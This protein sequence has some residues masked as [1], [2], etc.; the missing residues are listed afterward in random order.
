MLGNIIILQAVLNCVDPTLPNLKSFTID[1]HT[2]EDVRSDRQIQNLVESSMKI[3]KLNAKTLKSLK[4]YSFREGELLEM[5][6]Y[7]NF[8][9]HEFHLYNYSKQYVPLQVFLTQQT[10]LQQLG[11]YNFEDIGILA[12]FPEMPNLRKLILNLKNTQGDIIL[13]MEILNN[14]PR[15]EHLEMIANGYVLFTANLRSNVHL[16][17]FKLHHHAIISSG[18][19]IVHELIADAFPNLSNMELFVYTI[20]EILYISENPNVRV[21]TLFTRDDNHPLMEPIQD[22]A[23]KFNETLNFELLDTLTVYDYGSWIISN[24]I[25]QHFRL[26]NVIEL[27]LT[28]HRLCPSE[29]TDEDL[30]VLIG[31][32]PALCKLHLENLC[33]ITNA[34][35]HYLAKYAKNLKYL[36]GAGLPQV[37]ADFDAVFLEYDRHI[38]EIN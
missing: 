18:E 24:I 37:T 30:C 34:T 9:L 1:H 27:S 33:A 6:K 26:P 3:I 32:S 38:N 15:L 29:I 13:N 21:L 19:F 7:K 28:G 4:A 8:Q 23:E 10:D 14:F 31:Y 11:L 2:A 17:S 35:I 36:T 20:E 5:N 12:D 16:K 25:L 22:E